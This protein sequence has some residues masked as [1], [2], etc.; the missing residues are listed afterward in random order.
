L[1]NIAKAIEEIAR[2]LSHSNTAMMYRIHA[3]SPTCLRNLT[4]SVEI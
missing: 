4:A 3:H 2:F 1:D